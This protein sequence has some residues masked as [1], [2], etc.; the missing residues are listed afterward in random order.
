MF[1]RPRLF[2]LITLLAS[3]LAAAPAPRPVVST[4]PPSSPLARLG[5]T[6]CPSDSAFT[7]ITLTVP[8]DHFTPSDSRTLPVTFAVL[9][10][11]G[12]RQ[13]MFVTATGGPG[14]SGIAV[15]DDYT[16]TF[17]PQITR[18]FD[19]VFFDQRGMALSGGLACPQ[20]AAAF[21][22]GDGRGQTARQEAAL[23]TGAQTFSAG[24]VAE[25]NHPELLPY[26]GTDQAVEDLE[27]F[28]QLVGDSKFWLYGES[29]GTQYAQTY[30]ARHANRLAGLILDGTV[31]LTLDGFQFLAQ[32]AQAFN[33]TLTA[34]LRACNDDPACKA[35]MRGSAVG[36]YDGLAARLDNRTVPFDFPLPNGGTAHRSFAFPDLENAAASQVYNEGDRMMFN[37]A[38]AAYGARGALAPL[39]RLTYLALGLDPQT[40]AVIP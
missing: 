7:C 27:Q 12:R 9:A 16:A 34:A 11:T 10:A 31:D 19:I 18:H 8:L 23:K 13:G 26:L 30:A 37:R 22:Q 29:Y 20:A 6:P 1:L 28:R 15:A 40:L 21:Y 2:V 33:D 32:Q 38:L 3:S 24:C 39:M 5:G 17:D 36:V 25:V 4:V 35:D 14:T